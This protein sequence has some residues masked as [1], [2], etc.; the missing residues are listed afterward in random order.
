MNNTY[1]VGYV[2]NISVTWRT[3][4]G[5]VSILNANVSMRISAMLLPLS[6]ESDSR[7]MTASPSFIVYTAERLLSASEK[8]VCPQEYGEV[9]CRSIK[10]VACKNVFLDTSSCIHSRGDRQ[11]VSQNRQAPIG[12]SCE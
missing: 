8:S 1:V 3:E 4:N 10:P 7:H 11:I 2:L 12:A 9:D 5:Q 6:Q